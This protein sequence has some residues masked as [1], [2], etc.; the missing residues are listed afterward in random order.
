MFRYFV[1]QKLAMRLKKFML[2]LFSVSLFLTASTTLYADPDNPI[3]NQYNII[4]GTGVDY[5]TTEQLPTLGQ[6]ILLPDDLSDFSISSFTII[7]APKGG[8]TKVITMLGDTLSKAALKFIS[9]QKGGTNIL[10]EEVSVTNNTTGTQKKLSL[11]V[12]KVMGLGFEEH[13]WL[14]GEAGKVIKQ[15][16]SKYYSNVVEHGYGKDFTI[17]SF[18][19]SLFSPDG[20]QVAC[21]NIMGNQLSPELIAN[22]KALSIGSLIVFNNV[23]LATIAVEE[24]KQ[25]PAYSFEI[26]K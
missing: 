19:V 16:H 2:L 21:N 9:L 25:I 4:A 24:I 12:I 18:T 23:K 14:G 6:K 20:K 10:L 17:Q 11:T 3:V 1:T 26:V 22:I 15:A 5:I 13:F 7:I 8:E